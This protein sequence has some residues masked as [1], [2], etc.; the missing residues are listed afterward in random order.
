MSAPRARRRRVAPAAPS[1]RP[2]ADHRE[3]GGVVEAPHEIIDLL[4]RQRRGARGAGVE[5]AGRQAEALFVHR[6]D[7]ALLR[8][9]AQRGAA[10]SAWRTVA[11]E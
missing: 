9:L 1:L 5:E 2:G 7:E 4:E 3:T 11:E 6:G 8:C 10:P